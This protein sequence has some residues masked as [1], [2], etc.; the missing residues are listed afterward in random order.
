MST[1]SRRNPKRT[2]RLIAPAICAAVLAG[3]GSSGLQVPTGNT[4]GS[5]NTKPIHLVGGA[6]AVWGN[7]I[8]SSSPKALLILIHGGSWKGIDPAA[9]ESMLATAPV[10]RQL[11]YETL[12]VDYRHGAQGISDLN[13]IYH[14]ARKRV[15]SHFPICAVGV[16]AGGHI[17]LMLAVRNP[18]L[19]CVVDLAGPT[20]L[21]A[22]RSEPHGTISPYQI[23]VNAFGTDQL[24]A[25]SPALHA[26]SI[27]ARLL[28]LY[29]QNDPLVPVG[30]GYAM[31]RADTQAKL[32]VLP[33]GAA[34]FVHTGVGAPAT[35]SGVDANANAEAQK[36]EISFLHAIANTAS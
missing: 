6:K 32:I 16:S 33:P 31:A 2:R 5:L 35:K 23:A 15:G 9:F 20:N 24:T 36:T 7:Q 19:A 30:Q 28:L 22:L 14:L 10:Y 17:A 12:T 18:D 4:L 26:N 34:P 25:L 11:G 21:P 13:K 8:G 3:C 29:A 27:R 1:R